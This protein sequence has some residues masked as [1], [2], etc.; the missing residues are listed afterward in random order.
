MF[1]RKNTEYDT[2]LTQRRFESKWYRNLDGDAIDW[3]RVDTGSDT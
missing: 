2:G 3:D 1:S